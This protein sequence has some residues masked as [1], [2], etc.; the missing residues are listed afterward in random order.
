LATN[1]CDIHRRYRLAK[2]RNRRPATV[3][4]R[5][6]SLTSTAGVISIPERT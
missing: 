4:M 1:R 5:L 3:V 6:G 2:H